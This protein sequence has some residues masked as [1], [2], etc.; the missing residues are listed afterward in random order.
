MN[1][2]ELRALLRV[3]GLQPPFVLVGHSLGAL[4]AQVFWT[5]YAEDVAGMVLLDSPPRAWLEGR[6]FSGLWGMA[7]SAGEDL[8]AA[9]AQ[10]IQASSS[11]AGPLEAMASEHQEML[12]TGSDV[13]GIDSFR[14]LPL[15]VVAAG[16]ANL[17]FGDSATAYQEFWVEENRILAL[18]SSAGRLEVLDSIGH[19]MNRE[20]PSL[21]VE[22]IGR[23]LSEQ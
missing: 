14:D 21:L 15:L 2:R 9:A 6:R 7:V 3:A 16:R 10:A 11:E 4:N 12:R 1:A 5:E 17:A 19:G 23:F 22:L 8:E 13:A 20:A 18:R